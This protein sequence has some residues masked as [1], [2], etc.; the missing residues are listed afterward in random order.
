MVLNLGSLCLHGLGLA[1]L[2]R[3]V[4][5]GTF[6]ER[7]SRSNA[8]PESRATSLSLGS[9]LWAEWFFVHRI[10]WRLFSARRRNNVTLPTN[11]WLAQALAGCVAIRRD[12]ERL[13]QKKVTDTAFSDCAKKVFLDP[14][15]KLC[16]SK[17]QPSSTSSGW[18]LHNVGWI[19]PYP[20]SFFLSGAQ[21]AVW[22]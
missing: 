1:I 14:R 8:P 11:D 21:D 16:K 10:C 5:A 6:S 7:P 3:L 9:P 18:R 2:F 19:A 20:K 12:D 15:C 13:G 22:S 17:P 4:C